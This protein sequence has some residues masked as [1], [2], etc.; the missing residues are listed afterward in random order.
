M[1]KYKAR[2]VLRGDFVKGDATIFLELAIKS[3]KS[4][5]CRAP[6]AFRRTREA[7]STHEDTGKAI[8]IAAKLSV[9]APRGTDLL[10][11]LMEA[12]RI[13]ERGKTENTEQP[14]F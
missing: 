9:D 13:A 7:P 2:G 12:T 5:G 3:K 6:Q 11:Y 4:S 10:E 1:Q 8:H 14:S